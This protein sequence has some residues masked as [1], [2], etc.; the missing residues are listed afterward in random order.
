[1]VV[2]VQFLREL[3]RGFYKIARLDFQLAHD[4]VSPNFS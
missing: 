3:L 2:F 1:V 4:K